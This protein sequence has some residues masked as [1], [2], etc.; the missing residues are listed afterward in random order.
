MPQDQI[1]AAMRT[2]AATLQRLAKRAA[3][4]VRWRREKGYPVEKREAECAAL[5]FGVVALRE[6]ASQRERR[7]A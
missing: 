5:D 3:D 1:A 4:D 6:W 7:T 2:H